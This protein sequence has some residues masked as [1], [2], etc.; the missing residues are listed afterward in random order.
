MV[1]AHARSSINLRIKFVLRSLAFAAAA[2]FSGA[3]AADPTAELLP[4]AQRAEYRSVEGF[5]DEHFGAWSRS[6]LAGLMDGYWR[7]ADL[8]YDGEG[9]VYRGWQ[10]IHDHYREK[11]AST[12]ARRGQLQL[13]ETE[14]RPLGTGAALVRGTFQVLPPGT[15]ER[16]GLFVLVLRKWSDGWRIIYEGVPMEPVEGASTLV[17]PPAQSSEIGTSDPWERRVASQDRSDK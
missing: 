7:S 10:A 3:V 1:A 13:T 6:D 11:F 16:E 17:S 5:V 9:K 15:Q 8:V 12:W 4:A 14:I 2:S